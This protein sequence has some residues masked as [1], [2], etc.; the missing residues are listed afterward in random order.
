MER[1]IVS[2]SGSYFLLIADTRTVIFTEED[3]NMFLSDPRR[4][5]DF[6]LT[7]ENEMNVRLSPVRFSVADKTL[8]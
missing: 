7:L 8:P 3:I 5:W 4:A 1:T 2:S 6:R